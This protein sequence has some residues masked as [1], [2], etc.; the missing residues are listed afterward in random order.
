MD[1][2]KENEISVEI[3]LDENNNQDDSY[4]SEEDENF[5]LDESEFDKEIDYNS[6]EVCMSSEEDDEQLDKN[7]KRGEC[8]ATED[9]D[10]EEQLDKNGK[11]G[12]CGATED[13]DDEDDDD[14]EEIDSKVGKKVRKILS[15][16]DL[17][18]RTL[19]AKRRKMNR[20][21]QQSKIMRLAKTSRN[22]FKFNGVNN[23]ETDES[24]SS[25]LF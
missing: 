2:F 21:L 25:K 23:V 12:E 3:S 8:G 7:G 18:P 17:T 9:E 6:S 19:K 20:S 24:D 4:V 14:V 5:I 15:S 22:R 16:I 13:E 11:R 1:I 10:D